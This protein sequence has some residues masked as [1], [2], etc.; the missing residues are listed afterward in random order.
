MERFQ[1]YK[2]NRNGQDVAKLKDNASSAK[3]ERFSRAESKSRAIFSQCPDL[4][5]CL[6]S[7]RIDPVAVD[8]RDGPQLEGGAVERRKPE[9]GRR[10]LD[11]RLMADIGVLAAHLPLFAGNVIWIRQ[12][13]LRKEDHAMQ[14]YFRFNRQRGPV[15]AL[16]TRLQG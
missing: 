12:P 2:L 5:S 14:Y 6:L 3:D 15:N 4:I 13:F 8:R 11:Q 7:L 9:L 16:Q 10:Y 1:A